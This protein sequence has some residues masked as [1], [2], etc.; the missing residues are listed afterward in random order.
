MRAKWGKGVIV[1]MYIDY[2]KYPF[3]LSQRELVELY[4]ERPSVLASR[5]A[6]LREKLSIIVKEIIER[7]ELPYNACSSIEEC[8]LLYYTIL[9][10]A[11]AIGDK[12]FQNRV[13]LVY[14]K[15]ASRSMVQE[16]PE[17]LLLLGRKLGLEVLLV[18][19]EPD[20]PKIPMVSKSGKVV[21]FVPCEF[22]VSVL[23]YLRVV[24]RRLIHDQSY[25]LINNIVKNGYVYLDQKTYQ[26]VLEEA[27]LNTILSTIEE[28][29]PPLG[30]EEFTRLVADIKKLLVEGRREQYVEPIEK[31][32]TQVAV[33]IELK[34][35]KLPIIEDLFPPC[36]TRIISI[37]RSGGNPSHVE[38]FNLAAFLGSIGL[39]V[40]SVLEYFK[41][42]AD[43]NEKIA[44]YQVEHILGIRGGKKKYLPY[45]CEKMRTS[46]ICPIQEQC[47][48]GK[49][50]VAV[51]KYNIRK[52][53]KTSKENKD[54]DKAAG[55]I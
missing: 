54:A 39:D 7:G 2:S 40:D 45:S 55:G 4:V 47:K 50:P 15:Y 38:R 53:L 6:T 37:L 21:R 14:S 5:D 36:I 28:S 18:S 3:A 44:R 11:K 51:Y 46:G 10:L 13:A 8:V 52:Y 32:K 12:W 42:S 31:E 33:K 24:S 35:G 48:G 49:N 22:A 30:L 9:D 43:F 20:I 34:S 19:G 26:R 27:V 41:T 17:K 23:S 29:S 25:N 16:S 1:V